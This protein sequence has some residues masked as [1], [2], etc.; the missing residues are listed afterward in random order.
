MLTVEENDRLTKVGPGTPMGDLLRRYWQPIA[1]AAELDENPVKPVKLLGESLVLYRDRQGKLG[2]IGDT[3]PHRLVSMVYGIPEDEGLRCPYHG[4]LFNSSGQCVEMPAEAPDSTFPSRVKIEGYPV[5][6][7]AGLVF[8]YMGPQPT[9]L[10]PRWDMFVWDNVLRDIGSTVIPCNWL[11]IQENSL[12][13][14]HVEW[15]HGRFSNYVL[16]HLGR[17]DLKRQFLRANS[18]VADNAAHEKIGFDEFPHGIIKRRVISGMSEDD[19]EWRIGHPILFPN[20][21]R[22]GAN[23]QYRVPV[24]DE[25]TLHIWFTAYPQPPGVTAPVQETIP[26]HKIPLPYFNNGDVDWSLMDNN[27]GQDIVAWVTQGKIADRSKEKLGESDK[28]IIL[29]RRMLMQQLAIVEDGGEPMNVFRDPEQNACIE[30][31]WEGRED[32]WG[33]MRKG[34][35]RRTG[36]A[37]KYAPVLRD[38]VAEHEGEE[39]LSGPVH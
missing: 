38:M 14:V 2:L 16:E 26:H 3:C 36:Q 27:C 8:A 30:L 7:I 28:G 13:P 5:E 9:P 32:P 17:G 35:M 1:A 10:L 6:Q 19:P 33:Y 12:D 39:A 23:F 18:R 21:L 37:G 15:L 11:Q 22:V 24:D 4:W 25:N 29:Y 20:V 34:I 31:P